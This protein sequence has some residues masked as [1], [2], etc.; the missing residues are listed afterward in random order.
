MQAGIDLLG[1]FVCFL[2]VPNTLLGF[3]FRLVRARTIP[4]LRQEGIWR[5]TLLLHVLLSWL[6]PVELGRRK[7]RRSG[8]GRRRQEAGSGNGR[9]AVISMVLTDT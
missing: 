3:F 7:M 2:Q 8:R 6:H 9:K 1:Y 4:M 5:E